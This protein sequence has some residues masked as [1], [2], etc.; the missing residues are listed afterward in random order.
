[1]T[2]DK[3][4]AVRR[5]ARILKTLEATPEWKRSPYYRGQHFEIE[6]FST[7]HLEIERAYDVGARFYKEEPENTVRRGRNFT[8]GPWLPEDPEFQ[9]DG[10]AMGNSWQ[11]ALADW[12]QDELKQRA[13]RKFDKPFYGSATQAFLTKEL[14]RLQPAPAK[15]PA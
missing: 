4:A 1:M 7:Y 8:I 14:E 3:R 6:A 15:D 13:G 12:I 5:L 11:E 9:P 10:L 2:M